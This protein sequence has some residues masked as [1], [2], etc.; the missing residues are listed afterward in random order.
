MSDAG[1]LIYILAYEHGQ[2][3]KM[4]E[5]DQE[6]EK[7]FIEGN[8]DRIF[9]DFVMS[10]DPKSGA[11]SELKMSTEE[12][13]RGAIEESK[14][15]MFMKLAYGD[16]DKV[17][18]FKNAGKNFCFIRQ[19]LTEIEKG[20]RDYLR[21]TNEYDITTDGKRESVKKAIAKIENRQQETNDDNTRP[22]FVE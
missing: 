11:Q 8:I 19:H 5:E 9:K 16:L 6:Y 12:A 10:M 13:A 18:Q 22:D 15:I 21:S 1:K 17:E 20:Y 14:I 3:N 7:D 4:S 2:D